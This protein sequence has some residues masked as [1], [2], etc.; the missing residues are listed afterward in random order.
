MIEAFYLMLMAFRA[1]TFV[2]TAILFIVMYTVARTIVKKDELE[3]RE[4]AR[5]QSE[6]RH[7]EYKS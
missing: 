7:N 2:G 4:E 1:L 6:R 3:R 5:K